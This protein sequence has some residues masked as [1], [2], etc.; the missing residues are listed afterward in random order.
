MSAVFDGTQ[1][2]WFQWV[3]PCRPCSMVRSSVG[4]VRWLRWWL[5]GPRGLFPRAFICFGWT[6]FIAWCLKRLSR[7]MPTEPRTSGTAGHTRFGLCLAPA[8]KMVLYHTSSWRGGE[9]ILLV[10]AKKAIP[11]DFLFHSKS[12]MTF[13]RAVIG[14]FG[15]SHM[16]PLR[17]SNK[18]SLLGTSVSDQSV[19]PITVK[20]PQLFLKIYG[21][22]D[23]VFHVRVPRVNEMKTSPKMKKLTHGFFSR[24]CF[25]LYSLKESLCGIYY[26]FELTKEKS[27]KY[28]A[29]TITDA[30][31]TNDI[32][33]LANAPAKAETLQ[34]SLERG[35]ASIALHVNAHKTEYLCFNQTG[36]IFT[37]NDSTL[38]LVDKFI[39]LGSSV[40]ST[41]MDIN[42]RLAK[43]W[44]HMEVRPDR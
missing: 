21:F 43:A 24:T 4:F 23:Y 22:G 12:H 40:S 30:N 42:T 44:T 13:R 38:K 25:I 33:L 8:Q 29:E 31:Y 10:L 5:L 20:T 19:I 34:H 41:E 9:Q 17:N 16:C 11:C 27:R 6:K 36:N 7:K 3:R 26:P 39:Y 18:M 14:Q 2:G 1:L 15:P 32:S 35:I 37:L 28:P